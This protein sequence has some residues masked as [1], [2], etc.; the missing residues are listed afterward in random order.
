MLSAIGASTGEGDSGAVLGQPPLEP[1]RVGALGQPDAARGAAEVPAM[2]L[3]RRPQLQVDGLVACGYPA[4]GLHG[5]DRRLLHLDDAGRVGTNDV[6]WLRRLVGSGAVPVVSAGT[7]I[8]RF[9]LLL[10]LFIGEL[11]S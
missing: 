5:G 7:P 9:E 3:D 2:R 6:S 4:V 11:Y 8:A 10:A 1:R